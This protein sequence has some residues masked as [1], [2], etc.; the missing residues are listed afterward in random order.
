V[1]TQE[2]GA[3][4]K[5]TTPEQFRRNQLIVADVA[6][7]LRW[8]TIAESH[9]LT[10]RQCQNI[11]R[12]RHALHEGSPADPLEEAVA[13]IEAHEMAAEEFAV[14]AETSGND[15]IRLG[16]ISRRLAAQVACFNLKCDFGL[17]RPPS[18]EPAEQA[19]AVAL[20]ILST[21]PLTDEERDRLASLLPA[22][23][24]G[25]HATHGYEA[26]APAADHKRRN[27]HG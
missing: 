12:Q 5:L 17:I 2:R 7:G 19:L 18:A 14:L 4:K 21:K 26:E 24:Q 20:E 25:A 13:L 9:G 23:G 22:S 16:A 15:S 6:R 3:S 11:W 27:G 8:A 1:D 10:A